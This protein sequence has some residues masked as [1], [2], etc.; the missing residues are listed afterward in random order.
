MTWPKF[1]LTLTTDWSL[2][3]LWCFFA[4]QSNTKQ[5][6]LPLCIFFTLTKYTKFLIFRHSFFRIKYITN[7]RMFFADN[8]IRT[9]YGSFYLHMGVAGFGVGSIIYSC[10]QFG[11]YFDLSGDCQMAIVAMK[12]A[13]RILF[14][15]A[16]TV[17]IFSY[18]D[19]SRNI[20]LALLFSLFIFTRIHF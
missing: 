16:Q 18:T 11:G 15:V 3:V 6:N 1:C 13:L 20:I 5:S 12:P 14:L 8:V 7:Q 2:S 9:R 17:F 19:V 10:L 4:E